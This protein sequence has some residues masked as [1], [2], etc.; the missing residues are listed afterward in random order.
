MNKKP[1]QGSLFK[2]SQAV[3]LQNDN[4]EV[5]LLKHKSGKWLLPG[6]RLEARENWLDGLR[7][8]VKEETGIGTFEIAQILEVD[9]WDHKGEPHYGIFFA[10]K[11]SEIKVKLGEEHADSLWTSDPDE[12]DKL[13]FWNPAL[14]RIARSV[15]KT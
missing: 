1:A 15:L 10:A 2:V 14:H 8:E 12:I 13:D 5:L 6:G 11:T 3:V 7:R 4:G 9:S